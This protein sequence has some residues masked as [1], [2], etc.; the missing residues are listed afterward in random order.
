LYIEVELIKILAIQL[1]LLFPLPTAPSITPELARRTSELREL[2]EA[3]QGAQIYD[4]NY[5]G[6]HAQ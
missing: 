5:P 6:E 3:P 2:E 4:F 1:T